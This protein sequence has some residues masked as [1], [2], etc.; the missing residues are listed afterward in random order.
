MVCV[1]KPAMRN[2]G[3]IAGRK[4]G[5]ATGGTAPPGGARP[6]NAQRR[7][8]RL[9]ELLALI[10]GRLVD[11]DRLQGQDLQLRFGADL[12]P[13][14]GEI[15]GGTRSGGPDR[16]RHAAE[17]SFLQDA[18]ADGAGITGRQG[19]RLAVD[20]G[21]DACAPPM[22]GKGMTVAAPAKPKPPP[23][24]GATGGAAPPPPT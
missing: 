7:P 15:V 22:P 11:L 10:V 14:Q 6:G 1:P 17:R 12:Q 18:N 4:A 16:Q 21:D 23:A 24:G 13:D 8:G 5:R 3:M 20:D 2:I 19:L 9:R